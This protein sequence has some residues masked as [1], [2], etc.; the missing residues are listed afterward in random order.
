MSKSGAMGGG[1]LYINNL[2][3]VMWK[4]VYSGPPGSPSVNQGS[5]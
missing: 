2:F 4:I 1:Q 5:C 3:G